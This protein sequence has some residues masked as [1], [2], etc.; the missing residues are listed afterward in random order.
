[1]RLSARVQAIGESPTLA[2]SALARDLAAEGADVVDLSM[3]EPDFPTPEPIRRAGTEAIEAGHTGYTPARGL[4]TLREAIA[5]KLRGDGIS[6][7]E[8]QVIATPGAKHA[9]YIAVQALV[10]DGDEVVLLDPSWVS[11]E[12]MVTLAGGTATH[13][14]LAPHDF[15]LEPAL[16]ELD[17]TLSSETQLLLVNSPNNPSGRVYSDA[18][19]RGLRDLAV[20]YDVP[21][22]SD[23]IYQRIA[24]DRTPTSLGSLDGMAERTLTINGMS[25]A[26]AMTGWR[27]GY[28]A[29]PPEVIDAAAK[30]QSHSVSCA[31][32][33]VQRA[34]IVALEETDEVVD[35]MTGAFEDRRDLLVDR[36]RDAGVDVNVPEGAFYLMLPVD[37]DDETWCERALQEAH[38]AT[39]PGSAFGAPGYA[40]L[41]YAAS[42]DRIQTGID[43][44]LEQGFL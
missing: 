2:V 28:V 30:V 9:L 24:Y 22:I 20:E 13:V 6:C 43:R 36:L 1:M 21:V 37:A 39:I 26:Y 41:S 25:K 14:D 3:G 18:A 31:T 7:A 27:L 35:E 17:D 32:N 19:L 15:G 34:G 44:L 42:P 29:G 23:E 38:V 40:R 33:F 10:D 11:Y 4:P 12:P 16:D 5:S 8:D